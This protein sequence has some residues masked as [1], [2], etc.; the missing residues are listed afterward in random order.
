MNPD[1]PALNNPTSLHSDYRP[2]I[3]GLRA[4]AVLAVVTY[5]FF[6]ALLP[7]GLVGVDIFFVI[8]GFLINRILVTQPCLN[9]AT[10]KMF[11]ARR[12]KRLFPALLLVMGCTFA[13]GWIALFAD[14]FKELGKH[15]MAGAGFAS[16]LVYLSEAGYFDASAT[17][18]PLLHLWSLAVEEQFYLLWPLLLLVC[19][20]SMQ[21]KRLVAIAWTLS[22]AGNLILSYRHP[23]VA[24]YLPLTRFWEILTGAWLAFPQEGASATRSNSRSDKRLVSNAHPWRGKLT[25]FSGC[26]LVLASLFLVKA[27]A[28]FPGWQALVPVLGAALL[29]QSGHQPAGLPLSVIHRGLANRTMVSIGLV[30]YPLYLWHWPIFAYLTITEPNPGTTLRLM[31][32]AAALLLATL[33]YRALEKQVRHRQGA[34]VAVLCILMVCMGAIGHNIWRRNGLD[35]RQ[36]NYVIYKHQIVDAVQSL[37]GVDNSHANRKATSQL[38]MDRKRFEGLHPTYEG[39]LKALAARL[40]ADATFYR[41]VQEDF[42]AI[43]QPG[44]GCLGPDCKRVVQ[45]GE[46]AYGTTADEPLRN[47]SD[48]VAQ[49]VQPFRVVI[50]GDSHAENFHSAWTHAFPEHNTLR[51]TTPGCVPIQARFKRPDNRCSKLFATAQ[52]HLQATPAD[53]VLLVGRWPDHFQPLADDIVSYRALGQRLAVVGPSLDYA[54]DVSKLLLRY[55]DGDDIFEHLNQHLDPRKFAQNVA[56]KVWLDELGVPYIDKIALLCGDGQCRLTDNGMDLFITDY[57]HLSKAGARFVGNRIR[58]TLRLE[59]LTLR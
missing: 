11:Y 31:G 7:G 40:Q 14:E 44:D 45:S 9:A 54:V 24:Y 19:T 39:Q 35:F 36:V 13:F 18:K 12:I 46:G 50:I 4:I 17:Q 23:D 47:H 57:G 42:V 56:M 53:L 26:T 51:F 38:P 33:T 43:N 59:Q 1:A 34:T 8:S 16:N 28:H 32:M 21:R 25:A 37:T 55:R 30:S 41:Q 48:R 20:G 3:D 52:A 58:Q 27:D 22:F 15:L 6:P 2:D 10:L 49:S 29:I 5:H